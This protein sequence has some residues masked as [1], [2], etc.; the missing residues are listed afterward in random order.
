M[1]RPAIPALDNVPTALYNAFC[2][3]KKSFQRSGY[4][5]REEESL[6]KLTAL[7]L[8]LCLLLSL[9][10]FAS[11]EETGKVYYLNYKPEADQA[12]QLALRMAESAGKQASGKPY[13]VVKNLYSVDGTDQ[14][15]FRMISGRMPISSKARCTILR[16]KNARVRWSKVDRP[17]RHFWMLRDQPRSF[18]C[19]TAKDS[20]SSPK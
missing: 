17:G 8:T 14:D 4:T 7:L 15:W 5:K 11:A 1:Q 2:L 18:A 10:S 16:G 3:N 13:K 6:K 12:W 20:R 9:A 19:A